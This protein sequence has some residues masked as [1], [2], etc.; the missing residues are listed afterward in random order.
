MVRLFRHSS[1]PIASANVHFPR[2]IPV[3]SDL[4]PSEMLI[5]YYQLFDSNWISYYPRGGPVGPPSSAYSDVLNSIVSFSFREGPFLEA[6]AWIKEVPESSNSLAE[7]QTRLVLLYQCRIFA[8]WDDTRWG[9]HKFLPR[10]HGTLPGAGNG[11]PVTELRFAVAL[12]T[13]CHLGLP[14]FAVFHLF[15][16][17]GRHLKWAD[18]PRLGAADKWQIDGLRP[19]LYGTGF[20]VF[21]YRLYHWCVVW[22]KAWSSTLDD[23]DRLLS[24]EVSVFQS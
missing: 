21:V 23:V 16:S 20:A 13:T 4:H 8:I 3:E 9:I 19:C 1:R 2:V 11:V 10:E 22:E 12:Q 17:V 7:S 15:D 14:V 18:M 24:V 6:R 5:I